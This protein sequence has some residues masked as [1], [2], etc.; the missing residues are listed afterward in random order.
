MILGILL[1]MCLLH[2]DFIAQLLRLILR[3]L[4]AP[5]EPLTLHSTVQLL[6]SDV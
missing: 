1:L 4:S 3:V 5:P 6:L 2:R